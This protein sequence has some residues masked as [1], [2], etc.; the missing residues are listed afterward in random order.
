M[1]SNLADLLYLVVNFGIVR[2]RNDKN[3]EKHGLQHTAA[4]HL[5]WVHYLQH[6]IFY[7]FCH[8]ITL[9]ASSSQ[10][11]ISDLSDSCR[12]TGYFWLGLLVKCVV[13]S[14]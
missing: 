10:A 7:S 2:R 3:S 9:Y 5:L 12:E 1:S 11:L 14:W 8:W 13:T 4:L 6:V